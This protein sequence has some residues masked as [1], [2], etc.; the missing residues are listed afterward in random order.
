MDKYVQAW[1]TTQTIENIDTFRS[2]FKRFRFLVV[3][4][5]SL[6]TSQI[7]VAAESY[8]VRDFY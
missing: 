7:K 1:H 5:W 2:G 8:A 4:E 6:C 3:P